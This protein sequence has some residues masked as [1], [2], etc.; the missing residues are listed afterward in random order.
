VT[1]A[2]RCLHFC[3]FFC[4]MPC[5]SAFIDGFGVGR[6]GEFFCILSMEA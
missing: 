5:D 1:F 3:A 6:R 4:F 2:N